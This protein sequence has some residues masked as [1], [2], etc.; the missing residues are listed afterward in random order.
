MPEESTQRPTLRSEELSTM[1]SAPQPAEARIDAQEEF[2]MFAELL[3]TGRLPF[4][5]EVRPR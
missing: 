4:E 2:R 3:R 1:S 5:G